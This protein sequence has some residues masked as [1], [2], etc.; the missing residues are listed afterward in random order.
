MGV[1]E[2]TMRSNT[3][4]ASPEE[5]IIRGLAE[6]GGV[7][8]D[9]FGLRCMFCT[10]HHRDFNATPHHMKNCLVLRAQRWVAEHPEGGER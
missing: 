2:L 7:T 5:Q 3:E 4:P 1:A 8:S 9:E 10:W 6:Q